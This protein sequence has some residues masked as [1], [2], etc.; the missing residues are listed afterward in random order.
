MTGD[1][2]NDAL[3][4][5]SLTG[6]SLACVGGAGVLAATLN[7]YNQETLKDSKLQ[8]PWRQCCAGA[9]GGDDGRRGQRR[10]RL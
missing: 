6:I 1:G 5:K 2:V 7:P 8:E 3:A 4:C 10:T 9:R